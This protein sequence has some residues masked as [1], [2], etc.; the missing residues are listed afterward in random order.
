MC[1]TLSP[2]PPI[3]SGHQV[4]VGTALGYEVE[5]PQGFD[6]ALADDMTDRPF[7]EWA[8][9]GV[10]PAQGGA[11]A[12]DDEKAVLALPAGARG[13]A[14]LLLPNFR[15]LLQYNNSTAYALSVGHLADRLRGSGAFVR[16]WPRGDR[17]LTVSERRELQ[18]LLER[19]GFA[20]AATTGGI[21]P[22]T[23]AAIRAYQSSLALI[24]MVCRRD[25]P[26]E[27]Q[28]GP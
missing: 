21:G 14:F 6:Y 3:T 2:R 25:P 22:R 27:A 8:R 26:R 10:R 12:N 7:S 5:L 24:P 20:A 17:T 19:R 9:L 16:A 23:R 13:P 28:A 1:L 15:V 4:G 11:F 18:V